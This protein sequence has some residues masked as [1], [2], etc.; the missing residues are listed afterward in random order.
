MDGQDLA[1]Q[2][3]K[4]DA[5]MQRFYR[6][7]AS[8]FAAKGYHETTVDEIAQAMGVAKGT[9]YYNFENKE[10]LYLSIVHQGVDLFKQQL[11]QAVNEGKSSEER[12]A[13]LIVCQLKF[14]EQE[15]DL[16]SLFLTELFGKDPQRSQLATQMLSD[17]FQIFRSCIK[18]GIEAGDLDCID[19]ESATS[20][21]FGMITISALRYTRNHL[22]IPIEQIGSEIGKIFLRGTCTQPD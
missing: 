4:R 5:K 16:V 20:S 8:V 10:D 9:I 3:L 15:S 6:T 14:F 21:L 19:P 17:C 18:E 7:A 1:D 12:I 13:N 11:Q 2:R 22:P